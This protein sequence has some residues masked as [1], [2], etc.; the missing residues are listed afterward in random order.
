MGWSAVPGTGQRLRKV[1][2][3]P[4]PDDDPRATPMECLR[5]MREGQIVRSIRIVRV[6]VKRREFSRMSWPRR[7]AGARVYNVSNSRGNA[8]AMMTSAQTT[9]AMSMMKSPDPLAR[10]PSHL[11]W[12]EIRQDARHCRPVTFSP[13]PGQ[14]A[15]REANVDLRHRENLRIGVAPVSK[16]LAAA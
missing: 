14:T 13:P 8:I 15:A 12:G 4:G 1:D 3:R 5:P 9:V 6:W 2:I 11:E 10:R 7:R 16:I